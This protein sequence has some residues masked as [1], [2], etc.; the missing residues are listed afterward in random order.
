M[1][2]SEIIPST[3]LDRIPVHIMIRFLIDSKLSSFEKKLGKGIALLQSK[4]AAQQA[5]LKTNA[6]I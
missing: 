3:L 2:F 5:V 1:D 4:M 6:A